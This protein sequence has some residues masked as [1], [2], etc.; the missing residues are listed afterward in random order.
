MER[1]SAKVQGE[2]HEV[3]QDQFIAT[4]TIA[5]Q[6]AKNEGAPISVP[7]A[8][9]Q[10]ILESNW[11]RSQLAREANNLKGVKAGSSWRGDVLELPTKEYRAADDTW[12]TTVARWRKYPSWAEAFKDYGSLIARV[13]PHAAA[14]ADD[15]R[16]FL[17]QLTDRE[18]PRYATDPRYTDKV[19]SLIKAFNLDDQ[20]VD[21]ENDGLLIV[22]NE[23][24][25]EVLRLPVPTGGSIVDRQRGNRRYIRIEPAVK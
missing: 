14:V 17:E 12:Y 2:E 23:A 5:A 1:F 10:A 9:A 20:S 7:V 18:Y 11:G 22:F 6:E 3:T 4:A 15:P 13:Y 21:V 8:V 24:N 25:E 16:E 19:W